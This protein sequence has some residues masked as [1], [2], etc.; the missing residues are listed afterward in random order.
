VNPPGAAPADPGRP[1]PGPVPG[2]QPERTRLAW[3]RTALAATVVALLAG[4][5]AAVPRLTPATAVVAAALAALWT[6][7]LALCQRRIRALAAPRPA[8]A[9]RTAALLALCVVGFALL[10]GLMMGLRGR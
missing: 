5:L 6:A 3:R 8:A 10:A 7:T 9:R 4:R 1:E 2:R